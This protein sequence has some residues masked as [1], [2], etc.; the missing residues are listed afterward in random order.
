KLQLITIKILSISILSAAAECNF[1]TFEFIHNKI[2][3]CLYN[4]YVKKLVYIYANLRIHDNKRLNKLDEINIRINNENNK[5]IKEEIDTDKEINK[6]DD[7][8]LQDFNIDLIDLIDN[9]NNNDDE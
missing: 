1:S 8:I 9:L 7:N 6:G 4:D 5:S 2:H 3:N